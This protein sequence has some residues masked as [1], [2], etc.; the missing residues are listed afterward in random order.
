MKIYS[1]F[2][3]LTIGAAGLVCMALFIFPWSSSTQPSG[4]S[5]ALDLDDADGDQSVSSLDVSPEQVFLIQIFASDIQNATSISM[6]F[7]YDTR[8]LIYEGFDPGEALPNVHAIVQ[9]DTTSV[10]IGVS[11]LSG[12]ATVNGGWIGTVRFRTTASFSDVE[13]WLVHAELARGE[14][15]EAISPALGVALQVAA[16]RSPD[17]D[18][19]G[20]VGFSDFVAFAG[21]FGAR[22]GDGKYVAAYDLN[23]DGG[24]GFDDFVIF[25]GRFGEAANRAPAF[26][27]APP[28]TRSLAENTTSGQPI[29]DP[30][31]ATDAD[32][33]SLTY[34]LRGMHA[35]RFSI[36][37]RTGQLL[38]KEGIAYDHEAGEAYS[39]TVRVSDGKGGR[40][41]VGVGI[42]VT[43]VDEPPGAPPEGVAVAP[44]DT[45]LTVTWTAAPDEAG[46]PPVSGYEAAH[47]AADAEAWQE[48]LLVESR[49]DTGV[50]I[51]GLTNEQPYQVRVRT[52]NEEG[53][54]PWSE[55]V[56]GAPT[57]GPRPLGVIGDQ[58]VYV[59]R[60]LR[61]NLASLFTRPAL[62]ML[63]YGATSS[64]DAIATVAVSDTMATVRGVATGRATVTATAS[65]AWGN[66]AQTTFNVVVTSGPPPP[67]RPP[68][69]PPPPR[70]P[71]PPP[72]PRPPAQP[73][74][75]PPQP[76]PPPPPPANNQ[77]P[78]FDEGGSATRQVA[79]N[80]P[81][82]Q[83]VGDPVG[84]TDP[85]GGAVRYG[86]TGGDTDQFSI[87]PGIGQ[88][89]TRTDVD[90]NYEVKDR[91][92]VTVEAQDEQ[93]GR[94]TIAVTIDVTDDDNERPES[95]DR[96]TVTAS[97]LTSLTVGW[98]EPGNT[99]PPIT[100]YN[101]QYREGSSGAFTAGAH[102]GARTTTTISDLKSNTTYQIQVQAAS[103]EGTSP[104]SDSG[105]GTTIANQAP[106][107]SEGSSTTRSLAE[108]TTGVHNVG[109]PVTATD[110]DGGTL[111]YLL[112]GTDQSSFTLDVDQLQTVAGV[113][114]DYEEKNSYE[115]T[116][117]V[118][119][120][121]GG[122]NTI[123]VTID[124]I[125]QQE[126]PET[127]AA[128]DVSAASSTSLT[129]TW[130]E[131]VNTGPDVD[132]YD[133]Q[134]REGDSGGFTSWTHNGAALTTTITNL[135]PG[136]RY[137]AQV[138]AHNDEGASD[139]SPSGTGSTGANKPPVFT[140]GSSAA[141][142]L[143]ENTTGVQ[144]V[145]DPV[146]ATDPENTALT[147]SLEGTDADAFTIDTRSGQ[148]RTKSD[149][150]YNY[151]A[152]PRYV[153]SVKATDGHS[154]ERAITVLINLN[155]VNEPPAFTSDAA[156]EAG[157]NGTT[158]G[159]VVARDEDSADGITSYTITG[160]DD[161]D[162]FEIAGTNQ[163]RFKDAPD[164]EDPKDT[165][166][167]NEYI[168]VVTATGGTGGRA[169]TEAQTITVTVTDVNEPPH[170]TSDNSL[171]VKENI[172]FAGRMVAEDIDNA[173]GITGYT[174][175]GGADRNL[176]E[177]T[178][179]N[180]LH[181]KDDPDF[182]NPADNGR[183]NEYIVEVTATGGTDTRQRTVTQ[184]ITVTVEDEDEPP[185]KPDPPTVSNETEN[186]LTVTW[187]APTNTGPDITHYY[188]QYRE[189]D[190][191]DFIDWPDT[192]PSLTRTIT[193]L[194]S[195][196]TYQIR[197]QAENDEGKGAWSNS[198]NGTTLTGPLPTITILRGPY[199]QSGT[200]SSVIIKWRTDEA[201]ESVVHYGLDPNSLTLSASN[202]TSTTEH[203][204]QLTGLSA[205]VKYFYSVGT[206]SVTLAGGDRDHFVVTAPVPGTAKPTRIWVIGDSGTADRSARAVRNAF[207]ELTGSRDPDLW[208]MLGDNA[209]DEGTDNEYQ[210]AVFNTYPQVLPR[211]VLWPTLGNHGAGTSDSATESGPYYDIFSLPRNGEAGGVA[212]GTEAYYSFDYGNMHFVCLNS[213][214]DP[215][216]DGAMMTWL[217]ADLAA[218]DKEWIIAFWHRAPYSRGSANSDTD[219][220]Q[221]ALRQ[222]AVP[223]L[224]RYGVD[225][226][227]TG[228]THAY[229]RS[230]LID[231]H[232]GLSDTFT[233]AMKKNPGDGSAT[234]D[235]AY[236][237]PATVG[238]PHAGAVYV[239][240]GTAGVIKTQGWL[241]HPA[242]AVSFKILGSMVLDVNG[243][244]LD[245]IFMGSTRIGDGIRDAFT[246]LKLPEVSGSVAENT[247]AGEE[248]VAVAGENPE[249][250]RTYT[251]AGL[252]G[253]SDHTPFTITAQ[254]ELQTAAVLNYEQPADAD[255]N[256]IY[257]VVVSA[258]DGEAGAGN[259]ADT[260]DS[261]L[262]TIHVT[263]VDEAGTVRLSPDEPQA[264]T[265]LTATLNDPDRDPDN[266][267]HAVI[268]RWWRST[269]PPTDPYSWIAASGPVT[270]SVNS[271]E[272]TP[273]SGD[274]TRYLRA[275]ASYRDR[276]HT[277]SNPTPP[278]SAVSARVQAAP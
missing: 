43:D 90:Y 102:D 50:T 233:D 153:A 144:D 245:A 135:T 56:V 101:V 278:V 174:L 36:E 257:E 227:L 11:S 248:V 75:P 216:P 100:D 261:I 226:V 85:E 187:T 222:N 44:R 235:G 186:S 268:W 57:E 256:N 208:I 218:N 254:G 16:P 154:G 247:A 27:G 34:G 221:I 220:R 203:A 250:D 80:T 129:V 201:A 242:M 217:E 3:R 14:Q 146:G 51:A 140:D 66:G 167:N 180:Q 251:L 219:S 24:I 9:Q 156:F 12:A 210:A 136:R 207:L 63:T 224:E 189:G 199:L 15:A 197:V 33:D 70:P 165:G 45:A 157:E 37:A 190:S 150:T 133:V 181:F 123:E 151:E 59:D 65:D 120:G 130:T 178:N 229:E 23:G 214:T 240:A 92:S 275:T 170:F 30:V 192:G 141:R 152:K 87:V 194:R 262:V 204:V 206:S 91:Y 179:T 47:R 127:P 62:G 82:G 138:K 106:T 42:E 232:Y 196:S 6:R 35:D 193:G 172:Q 225:L 17:F 89:Q 182:E 237:K 258:E 161:R 55:P 110:G 145:G 122:S 61:V 175:T 274:V 86:L 244:R 112:G 137:E 4:F 115:V 132:D 28:V 125:D 168:V 99:G 71:S 117:R 205:D 78:T 131:P 119:D 128:P 124:L 241:D 184:T 243:N 29:G 277:A 10:R 54:G 22:L 143:D 60:D 88:L 215:S 20:L 271:S 162:L 270:S 72:P 38:T 266:P 105:N 39:L 253:H 104:W 191:G 97:T 53:A 64:D 259:E 148:L 239:V 252:N 134:Y 263:D 40:A 67:P 5:L 260:D 68:S 269:T 185:G 159:E 69:P 246:I 103:D 2:F 8:Q 98:I 255:G 236:Q 79:E 95:P 213:E 223:L 160:G 209:Y 272:Y 46:K 211:T 249:D 267:D 31:I 18:G 188:V 83:D 273:Q 231:G 48:G 195:G 173:D 32:G 177:I 93:G 171:Q 164:F 114:Y 73:P 139:W 84:A 166:R 26:T 234:G 198:V 202:T 230:H 276:H 147:Y 19:N 118:E 111:R 77:A 158:V 113:T 49:T 13:I 142:A 76:P 107:F 126:P 149:Q 109:N 183:N 116:V 264:Q 265:R 163:L 238:A 94:A 228:H 25:A 81:G 74:R 96:P 41:A 21:A 155:D 58:T 176:F 169:L 1:G 212:S 121:Q 108:N 7:G 200:S 52:L